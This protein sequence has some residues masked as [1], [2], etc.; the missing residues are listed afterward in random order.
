VLHH[1]QARRSRRRHGL[2]GLS[3]GVRIRAGVGKSWLI[4][5]LEKRFYGMVETYEIPAGG[6][7][8]AVQVKAAV[9]G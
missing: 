9:R 2:R 1:L 6:V 5:A 4:G 7:R 8:L 3:K